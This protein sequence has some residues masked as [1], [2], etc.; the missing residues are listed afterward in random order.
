MSSTRPARATCATV[1]CKNKARKDAATCG[2]C[3]RLIDAGVRHAPRVTDASLAPLAQAMREHP[4]TAEP[5]TR[6]QDCSGKAHAVLLANGRRGHTTAQDSADPLHLAACRAADRHLTAAEARR[7]VLEGGP[8]L[9]ALTRRAEAEVAAAPTALHPAEPVAEPTT[10]DR[11]SADPARVGEVLAHALVDGLR[12]EQHAET[13]EALRLATGS[14]AVTA[15]EGN[16]AVTSTPEGR[17]VA[18]KVEGQTV[19]TRYQR[20]ADGIGYW[21]LEQNGRVVGFDHGA[22]T[23]DGKP[24]PLPR[25]APLR[26]AVRAAL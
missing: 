12:A 26:D 22:W 14:V 24:L 23:L 15:R 2:T 13:A 9:T 6:E 11:R 17:V 16:F 4:P 10:P 25:R 21:T 1:G 3:A 19:R 8:D 18:V 7:V 20:P 5:T